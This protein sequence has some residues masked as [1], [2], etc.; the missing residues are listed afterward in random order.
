[1]T[2]ALKSGQYD[3]SWEY[4]TRQF[5]NQCYTVDIDQIQYEF[6][7]N[8]ETRTAAIIDFKHFR[9]KCI[10]LTDPECEERASLRYQTDLARQ[11]RTP[12]FIIICF[13]KLDDGYQNSTNPAMFYVVP[14]NAR[15]KAI[16]NNK[17]WHTPR[18]LARL[19]IDC[20]IQ[21]PQHS[22]LSHLAHDYREYDLQTRIDLPL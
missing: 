3:P 5:K 18:E 7:P 22:D 16:A 10:S 13:S 14:A 15:A 2:R 11:L 20:R 8:G 21:Q 17:Q 6:L 1:M 4:I 19:M 12:F 9:T